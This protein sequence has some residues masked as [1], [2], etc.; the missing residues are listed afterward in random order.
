MLKI[1]QNES[2]TLAL[3]AEA[4]IL[5]RFVCKGNTSSVS[6]E[7]IGCA[8]IICFDTAGKRP[9]P[10]RHTSRSQGEPDDSFSKPNG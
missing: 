1:V 10:G 3:S 5:P 6:A 4:V 7:L 9:P 2:T 8:E